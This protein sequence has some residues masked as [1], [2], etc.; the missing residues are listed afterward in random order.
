MRLHKLT[1]LAGAVALLALSAGAVLAQGG[2]G[3]GGGQR[4]GGMRG[5]V[6]IAQIPISVLA[7]QLNLTD[8]QKTKIADIQTKL[9]SDLKALRS[10]GQS[11]EDNRQ[12]TRDLV[13]KARSDVGALLNDDQKAKMPAVME[14]IGAV[15]MSGIPLGVLADL[16]LTSDQFDKIGQ[17]AKDARSKLQGLSR[18]DRQA[19][20]PQIRSDLRNTVMGVLTADQKQKVEDYVKAHPHR[21]GPGAPSS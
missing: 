12:A 7:S 3:Q 6:D 18:E 2:Q 10:N 15:A 16:S 17:A 9:R 8:D 11:Q 5:G 14:K 19:Q 1:L 4:R 13:T 20:M 21:N